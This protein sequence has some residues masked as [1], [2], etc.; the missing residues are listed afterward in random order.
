MPNELAL[1]VYVLVNNLIELGEV[2]QFCV[3]NLHK[4]LIFSPEVMSYVQFL[5]IQFILRLVSVLIGVIG[6]VFAG[7]L[8][9][10]K[11]K[12]ESLGHV[13]Q[14]DRLDSFGDLVSAVSPMVNVQRDHG[15][16]AGEGH[17]ANRHTVVQG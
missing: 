15:E 17:Q 2:D 3:G 14:N 10:I 4:K 7:H 8:G 12:E 16:G 5:Q 13:T 1:S 6:N 9:W 11:V